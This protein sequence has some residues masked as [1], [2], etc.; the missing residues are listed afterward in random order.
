MHWN[1]EGAL[2]ECADNKAAAYTDVRRAVIS[3]WPSRHEVEEALT[4]LGN[5]F[6]TSHALLPT[7]VITVTLRACIVHAG[8]E[9][10]SRSADTFPWNCEPL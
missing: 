6:L 4:H 7:L 3:D 9:I 10:M 5:T 2:Q 8:N 1:A